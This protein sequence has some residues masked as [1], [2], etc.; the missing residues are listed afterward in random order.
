MAK[1]A[2]ILSDLNG[3]NGSIF[4][5]NQETAAFFGFSVAGAGD[6]NKDGF[7]DF[8]IG[9]PSSSISGTS[10]G[11]S[12]LIFGKSNGFGSTFVPKNSLN[13][14][15][16]I[17]FNGIEFEGFAGVSVDTAGDV[18]KDGF[19]DIIIGAFTAGASKRGKAYVVFGGNNN[20]SPINLANFNGKN[21]FSIIGVNG[22]DNL[23]ISVSTAG[24]I[25]KDG[26]D[27]VIVG[28]V[29]VNGV[30]AAYVILGGATFNGSINPANLNGNNG[31]TIQGF[32]GGKD[33]GFSVDTAGDVNKDGFDDLIITGRQLDQ[34]N[35]GSAEAYVIYGGSTF[36]ASMSL[37]NLNGNNGFVIDGMALNSSSSVEGET[38]V[39][40]GHDINGDGFAD[41]ILSNPDAFGNRSGEVYVIFGRKNPGATVEL[42][43]LNGDN[44]FS[45]RGVN[46][47]D[48]LG[49]A[50]TSLDFNGDGYDDVVAGA[51]DAATEKG[52]IYTIYGGNGGF[53]STVNLN[54]LTGNQGFSIEGFQ[55]GEI[56]GSSLG[57]AGDVNGDG[58]EDLL[59]GA[60]GASRPLNNP[61]TASGA[62][63]LVYGNTRPAE[64][65]VRTQNRN[66]DRVYAP[67]ETL[68][69]E[70]WA[71][72]T[73]GYQDIAKM[74]IWLRDPAQNWTK[75]RTVTNF[76]P[77]QANNN[78]ATNTNLSLNLTGLKTGS[79]QLL[80]RAFDQ[81]GKRSP[82]KKETTLNF[83]I[84]RPPAETL[85]R[86]K[87]NNL[88]SSYSPFEDLQ[89]EAWA[90]DTDG[91]KDIARIEL[92]LQDPTNNW[93]KIDTINNFTAYQ[94]NPNWASS[95]NRTLDLKGF[96]SGTYKLLGRA[97]DKSGAKTKS[98][99][100]VTL[101]FQ[102]SNVK[103]TRTRLINT[104]PK[105][106]YSAGDTLTYQAWA[107]DFNGAK[108]VN[109][110][111]IWLFNPNQQWT[112]IDTIT[113]FS[114]DPS[115]ST[116][117]GNVNQTLDLTGFNSGSYSIL[118]R[119]FD[120]A[121]LS[122]SGS[123]E[124]T[125]DFDIA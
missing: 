93:T 82:A 116:W 125:I 115:D 88:K 107:R 80:G 73:D 83:Q 42:G 76:S 5:G 26:F 96:D 78:W 100:E 68:K 72:D 59:I 2:L 40:G 117:A 101:D 52:L 9:E 1:S 36:N 63:Y 29:D 109:K 30:G 21:G 50:I 18:N 27:D 49:V 123:T 86:A 114:Q 89:Y 38:K 41:L 55:L 16:G 120:D 24:D 91:Y 104:N 67:G 12:F 32:A 3:T 90:R 35:D 84:N 28:A 60:P 15:N 119:A 45:F 65:L 98:A 39:S 66:D 31:F 57:N 124:L 44:G 4:N 99:N 8:I 111:D 121:G 85:I 53:S 43:N 108:D 58:V 113:S 75:V 37:T 110:V 77:Y 33:I 97:F 22:Q 46:G 51:P 10:S 6:F 48:R 61:L 69:Y 54:N 20:S 23:G 106:T 102:V 14:N 118:A 122:S 70:A 7:D 19:D 25:N 94:P 95:L 79:Y 17:I 81:Y 87:N 64:T 47:G 112:K 34:D 62:S 92:W 71:R 11:R 13:G 74:D 103:P 56:A 105:T